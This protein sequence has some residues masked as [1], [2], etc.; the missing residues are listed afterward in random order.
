MCET[1]WGYSD[2]ASAV[3]DYPRPVRSAATAGGAAGSNTRRLWSQVLTS[4]E[5]AVTADSD[6]DGC[7]CI[8]AA[9]AAGITPISDQLR[10]DARTADQLRAGART[11]DPNRQ[12]T[13]ASQN[14]TPSIRTPLSDV[15]IATIEEAGRNSY[16]VQYRPAHRSIGE[17]FL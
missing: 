5:Q 15:S 16:P 8:P 6:G 14:S 17:S 9:V 11:A 3:A 4:L 10:A 1:R 12:L 13:P 7:E 2:S